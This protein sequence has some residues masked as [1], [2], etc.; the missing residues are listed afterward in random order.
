MFLMHLFKTGAIRGVVCN[1]LLVIFFALTSILGRSQSGPPIVPVSPDAAA[2]AKM[3]NYNLN[4]NTGVP[5]ISIPL[6]RVESGGFTL[7][8]GINYHAGGFKVNERATSVGLGW[9]LDCDLQITRT[10]NGLDDF[11]PTGYLANTKMKAFFANCRYCEY[12]INDY[13]D[14]Y[15][16]AVGEVDGAPDKFNFKL[17]GKSGSFYFQKDE[18]GSGY[19]I[20][21]VPFDNIKITFNNNLFTIVD[22]DGTTYYFGS[23]QPGNDLNAML[24]RG[25]EVAGG[26]IDITGTCVDC[27]V[28]AWKC[29]KVTDP[30]K[31]REITF[32]YQAKIKEDFVANTDY[33]TFY[34]NTSPCSLPGYWRVQ[35]ITNLNP[36]I[37]T[38]EQL[39]RVIPF[40]L[41]SSPK[42]LVSTRGRL[43]LHMPDFNALNNQVK[44]IYPS[45]SGGSNSGSSVKGLALFR[46]MFPDGV[47]EFDGVDELKKIT[48]RN[49]EN[50]EVRSFSF[51][52]SYA[53]AA[54]HAGI[55]T[56][57]LDSIQLRT[58][59]EVFERYILSY[60]NKF[61]FGDHL[62]GQDA[63]G[64]TNAQT[65]E[66]N[67]MLDRSS[68]PSQVI[69]QSFFLNNQGGCTQYIPD[70]TF[71]VGNSDP[72]AEVPR[73][74]AVTQNGML[75]RIVYP[76]G[77]RV[78]FDFE[79]NLY[80]ELAT[81]P[82][83]DGYHPMIR[84]GG[85]VRIKSINYYDA[86][87]DSW[88]P[89]MQKSYTYGD[90]EN[91]VGLL[92]NKPA[93][94]YNNGRLEYDGYSYKQ[95]V[96]YVTGVQNVGG[97]RPFY[98]IQ[99]NCYSKRCVAL[100]S[101]DTK[102]TYLP[103]SAVNYNYSNGAP[104]YYMRV[105]EYQ[106]DLGR[107]TGKKVYS[108]YPPG[109][110]AQ[111]YN[112][113]SI[114]PNTNI[115]LLQGDGLIGHLKAIQDFKFENE[116]FIPVHTKQFTYVKYAR[117]TR[118]R[119]AYAFLN[120]VYQ[121]VGG[122][123]GGNL[124]SMYNGN[125]S[126]ATGNSLIPSQNFV[127]GEYGIDVAKILVA[128]ESDLWFDADN[129][130]IT[131]TIN[132]TYGKLPYLNAT[133]IDVL[134]SKGERT[135]SYF[136]YPY[137]FQG[138][139]VYD[140]M[141]NSN[142][143]DPLVETRIVNNTQ[144]SE[145][146]KRITNYGLINEGFGFFA[147]VSIEASYN[148]GPLQVEISY[149]KYDDKAN[150]LETRDRGGII[151]SYLWGYRNQYPVAEFSNIYY[152]TLANLVDVN[153]LHSVTNDQQLRA[154]LAPLQ[155]NVKPAIGKY[156]TYFPLIGMTSET[157]Y[158]GQRTQYE[159]DGYGRLLR[160]KDMYGSI[161]KK[162]KYN[163]Y[164]IQ[165]STLFI[166]Q[167]VNTPILGSFS[168]TC[169]SSQTLYKPVNQ[170][171][172]GGQI[173]GS[174]VVEANEAAENAFFAS[175]PQAA[176]NDAACLESGEMAKITLNNH[177]YNTLPAPRRL[178]ID[179]VQNN[180]VVGSQRFPSSDAP[181]VAFYFKAGT[182]ILSFRPPIDYGSAIL[183]YWIKGSDGTNYYHHSG[184]PIT[185]KPGVA[186]EFWVRNGL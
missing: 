7:P 184:E 179:F 96:G 182:Y 14:G 31:T 67:G 174:T 73:Q 181:G 119:V 110:F 46:I 71:M 115:P 45:E 25:L 9:S 69:R 171:Y 27:K 102:T 72:F 169:N 153:S 111:N 118:P 173:G 6:Y 98:P 90:L 51:F 52:Q 112:G 164:I 21:P 123:F 28:T 17:L 99:S 37:A 166:A 136:K 76:T 100:R 126:F 132:Y 129:K 186:Y 157:D 145:I 11:A 120:N 60:K 4:L 39:T 104:I 147:P 168:P 42:Y 3:V 139:S 165:S 77:G 121:F 125:D 176:A 130:Q 58:G 33:I 41:L 137:D 38:Y 140:A 5:E 2:L 160:I 108:Y 155:T 1:L 131:N 151:K 135:V 56:R 148:G 161:V 70:A 103:A 117:P 29:K 80:E 122:D 34:N 116:Q 141:A 93:R 178:F 107:S 89:L 133:S 53:N 156:F 44:K 10:I 66:P 63:W 86:G 47:I 97:D 59:T 172:A 128:S 101:V 175:P 185:L 170:V 94:K 15:R 65:V 88:G 106:M 84:V 18:S 13:P 150:I 24:G 124:E 68:V 55:K 92:M 35:D 134:N 95:T 50:Q 81:S 54:F 183:K 64:Y 85:G 149:N 143:I 127:N 79:S 154:I 16:L 74:S 12:P 158:N 49:S 36:T 146:S 23:D 57:Y 159:Y 167:T 109:E 144:G 163:S 75:H 105:T 48:V 162:Y 138:H 87:D 78:E 152:A 61:C 83:V 40:Y 142:I 30:T 82:E 177:M 8:I 22:T 180:S 114:I 26:M 43:E 91:G 32:E 113:S 62:V 19:T 20:V